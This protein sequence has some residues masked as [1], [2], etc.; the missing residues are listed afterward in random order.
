MNLRVPAPRSYL[1]IGTVVIGA[2]V[3]CAVVIGAVVIG[4]VV[5][6]AV[7]ICAVVIGA[8]VIM[9]CES[10]VSRTPSLCFKFISI[11]NF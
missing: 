10:G 2:V 3:I 8:V 9:R 5:I 1:V 11:M 7:V 6:C 4:A